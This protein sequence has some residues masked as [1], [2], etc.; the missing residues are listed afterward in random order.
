M[1]FSLYSSVPAQLSLNLYQPGV[2][3]ERSL[4]SE[5]IALISSVVIGWAAFTF[6]CLPSVFLM[7]LRTSSGIVLLCRID[8]KFPRRST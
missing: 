6:S 8:V 3:I 5:F 4:L 1:V 7:L 2:V